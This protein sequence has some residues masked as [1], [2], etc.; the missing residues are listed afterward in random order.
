MKLINIKR[1]I[2]DFKNLQNK[3]YPIWVINKTVFTEIYQAG[4]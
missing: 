1:S 2:D 4:H 3:Y